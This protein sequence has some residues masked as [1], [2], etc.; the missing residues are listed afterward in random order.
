MYC[1]CGMIAARYCTSG[2]YIDFGG[3]RTFRMHCGTNTINLDHFVFNNVD[4][5]SNCKIAIDA[6]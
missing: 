5:T 1:A 2:R 3:D 6:Y 4:Y